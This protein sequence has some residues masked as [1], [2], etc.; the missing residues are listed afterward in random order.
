LQP[1]HPELLDALAKDFIDH[2]YDL[3][4]L[5]RLIAQSS[6]YQLSAHFDNEWK[7]AY[8]PYFAR[9]FVRRLPAEAVADAVSQATG[10]F[11][12]IAVA[13]TS[14]KVKYV[15]Q[16]RSPEDLGGK[17]LQPVRELLVTFGQSNRDKG[18]K[19]PA[20]NMVQA[21]SL[22]NGA[23]VKQRIRIQ[24]GSRMWKLA[25]AD[26]PFS[27]GDAVEEM[28]LAFLSRYPRPEEKQLAVRA[29]ESGRDQGFQD[30]AWSLINKVEF[31]HNY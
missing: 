24:E 12:S 28:Y 29:L 9:R 20:G 23:F 4:Y 5:I 13:D 17:D 30:I 26:P 3:R 6:A 14:I 27:S 1:T 25:H 15:M 19:D 21:A 16:T 11:D 10:V 31:I 7:P 8:A 18:E 22:L 2:K